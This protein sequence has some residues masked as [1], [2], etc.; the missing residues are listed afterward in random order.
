M[1]NGIC[2]KLKWLKI[3]AG[4]FIVA[5]SMATY[6]DIMEVWYKLT[7]LSNMIIGLLFIVDGILNFFKKKVPFFLM[8]W[9]IPYIFYTWLVTC[10]GELF[11]AGFEFYEGFLFL[12]AINPIFAIIVFLI[13]TE[14]DEYS[15]KTKII[16]WLFSPIPILLYFFFDLIKYLNTGRFV[17]GFLPDSLNNIGGYIF[18]AV[19]GY[20][21]TLLMTMILFLLNDFIQ[22]HIK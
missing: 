15:K 13:G 19:A 6:Y 7:F 17:Y 11:G 21:L 10:V 20:F 5:I 8:L 12:H 1:N 14:K 18:Y 2:Y 3:F 4:I 22:K 16:L 9:F